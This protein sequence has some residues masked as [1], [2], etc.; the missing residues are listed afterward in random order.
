MIVTLVSRVLGLF[1]EVLISRGFGIGVYTDAYNIAVPVPETIFALVGLAISTAFLPTLS[2][3]KAK[4]GKE[5][6]YAFANNVI[7]ILFVVSIIIFII[8][9]IFA[10]EIA[11]SFTSS[12]TI[13]SIA[14]GL[15]KITL[16]NILFLSVNACFTAL[17][18]VNED[19]VIPSILGL[20]FNLPMILYLLLCR[21]YDILGLTIANVV[22]NFFRVV[23][24]VPS[25]IA[26]GYKY[27]FCINLKDERLK[28]IIILI[29]P[30]VIGAGAN[31]LNM[32]VDKYIAF[33]LQ[34]VGAPSALEYAQKL[35]V[36][37]NTIIVTS[38][39]S[40][41][42]PLMANMRNTEDKR[43]FLEILKKSILY[44]AILLIPITVGIIIYNKE[45]VSLAYE[46]GA[47]GPEA[48]QV[49]SIAMF[50]Y[51]FGVFFTGMR[52]ILNSTLFTMGKTK[53]TTINGI[54]GVIINIIFCIILSKYMGLM[55]IALASVIAMAVTAIL[56][57]RSIVK[58]EKS[59][60]IKDIVKKIGLITINSLIMGLIIITLIVYLK[61]KLNSLT[62]LLLG[63]IVGSIVYFILC[64]LFR[65]EE[66]IEIKDFILK[67]I[68][69]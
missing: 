18:Q 53:I 34:E 36:F 62:L 52:D 24:Q 67:K 38:V 7:S 26:H 44:L 37:I 20:F 61:N 43:G 19:F 31:S 15:L 45:I 17:L 60:N 25:L 29:I 39:N 56:L 23:V 11:Y 64:Y 51:G 10:K 6:M 41:V 55:G 50:G 59:L 54:I 28:A 63:V 35:I 5:E 14:T 2:K 69:R 9:S 42:Y 1:R 47:F 40:I 48:V 30:V 13:A 27:K 8:S 33:G 68:N 4:K 46:R 49:T 16:L 32:L 12:E 22:G 57:F 65:I 3:I 21:N 58:L 66:V